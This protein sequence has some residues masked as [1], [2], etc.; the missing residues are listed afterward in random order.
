MIPNNLTRKV[1]EDIQNRILSGQFSPGS[2][3][4]ESALAAD[5]GVSRTPVGEA[6]RDLAGIGLVEQVPRVGTVVRQIRRRD[7]EELYEV[8][9]ALEPFA[10][11]LAVR[12]ISQAD[13]E[14]L[15]KLCVR[16]AEIIAQAQAEGLER[17]ENPQHQDYLG[18]DMGFHTIIIHAAGNQRL[19]RMIRES[20]VMVL[21]FAAQNAFLGR[22]IT[23]LDKANRSHERILEAIKKRDVELARDIAA[24][25]VRVS[26]QDSLEVFDRIPNRD[27]LETEYLPS[28]VRKALD[29]IKEPSRQETS[30]A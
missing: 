15:E 26:L 16:M 4:S 2:V 14:S 20:H 7:L 12:R 11:S 22:T 8:R 29:G 3:L 28:S 19:F 5:L 10:T 30:L 6:L 17:L 25:H 27:A 9:E 1:Y 23:V 24:E 13:I 21:L 18:A